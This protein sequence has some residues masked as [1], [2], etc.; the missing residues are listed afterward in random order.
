MSIFLDY[1]N[2]KRKLDLTQLLKKSRFEKSQLIIFKIKSRQLRNSGQ[3]QKQGREIADLDQSSLLSTVERNPQAYYD[4]RNK[5]RF[6]CQKL[7]S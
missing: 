4:Y 2:F 3:F 7:N 5:R 1:F 6:V